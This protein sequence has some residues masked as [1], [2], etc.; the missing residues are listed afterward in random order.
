MKINYIIFHPDA[1]QDIFSVGNIK[2]LNFAHVICVM[3]GISEVNSTVYTSAVAEAM[4]KPIAF[5][6]ISFLCKM[7]ETF[8]NTV[9]PICCIYVTV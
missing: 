7:I 1:R 8:Y 3:L 2:D 4:D 5:I 9:V 6:L